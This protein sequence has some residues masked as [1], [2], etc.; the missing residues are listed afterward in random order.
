[1]YAQREKER[2]LQKLRTFESIFV[3]K[4]RLR[5]LN[6]IDISLNCSKQEIRKKNFFKYTLFKE[7][8]V[9]SNILA[10]LNLN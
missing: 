5:L 2:I 10:I 7:N 6:Y 9:L 4:A 8:I 1:M 3:Y